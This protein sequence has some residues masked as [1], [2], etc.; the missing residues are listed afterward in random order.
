[1]VKKQRCKNCPNAITTD[2]DWQISELQLMDECWRGDA[3]A[4]LGPRGI[5]SKRGL[6]LDIII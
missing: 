4:Y 5:T 3:R 1:M 2:H 6:F